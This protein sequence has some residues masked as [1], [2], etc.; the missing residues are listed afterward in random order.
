MNRLAICKGKKPLFECAGTGKGDNMKKLVVFVVG[1][2]LAVSAFGQAASWL[3]DSYV[4]IRSD[5]PIELT[6]Y[7]CSAPIGQW[8]FI[9]KL[10]QDAHLGAFTNNVIPI[11]AFVASYGDMDGEN[12]LA[13]LHYRVGPLNNTT[14]VAWQTAVTMDWFFEENGTNTYTLGQLSGE[15]EHHFVDISHLAGGSNYELHLF[16]S[17]PSTH[18]SAQGGNIYD[19]NGSFFKAYFAKEPPAV[20][21]IPEPATVSLLGVGALA[22]VLHRKRRR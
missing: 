22:M 2:V 9:D 20:V 11:D 17:L 13:S 15:P 19:N 7:G 4:K 18:Q 8:G 10:F 14:S 16:F 5:N 12:N 6:S 21:P 1:A 3:G